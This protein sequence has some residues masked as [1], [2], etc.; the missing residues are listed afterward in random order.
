MSGQFWG[1]GYA[2][3]F[4]LNFLSGSLLLN[5]EFN[6]SASLSETSIE[7]QSEVGSLDLFSVYD[8]KKRKA[9][10]GHHAGSDGGTQWSGPRGTSDRLCG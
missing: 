9:P 3:S 5:R 4:S 2:A 1:L 6:N 7:S 10:G 8:K